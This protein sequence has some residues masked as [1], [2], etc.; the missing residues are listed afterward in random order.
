M[1]VS[2][3]YAYSLPVSLASL[4]SV[5]LASDSDFLAGALDLDEPPLLFDFLSE[6]EAEMRTNT[7]RLLR[8]NFI[9]A[10]RTGLEPGLLKPAC[11][12]HKYARTCARIYA[13]A[14]ALVMLT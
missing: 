3:F 14:R 4:S 2:T 9:S 13:L 8:P 6:P 12:L 1:F 5:V 7:T 10:V 11:H